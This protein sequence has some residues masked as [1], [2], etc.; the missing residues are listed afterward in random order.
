MESQSSEGNV[1][2][3]AFR[4]HGGS[5]IRV[6]TNRSE[7]DGT[8]EPGLDG[9]PSKHVKTTLNSSMEELWCLKVQFLNRTVGLNLW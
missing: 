5:R 7:T 4:A 6:R 2:R 1:R 8:D 9:P 3:F